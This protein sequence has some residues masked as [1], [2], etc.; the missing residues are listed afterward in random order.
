MNYLAHLYLSGNEPTLMIGNFIADHVK[1]KQFDLY[2]KEIQKGILLHRSIDAFTDQHAV[3]QQSKIIL[4]PHF[5]KYAPVIV[6]VFY[7]HFLARDWM[8]YHPQTLE[9]YS[10]EVYQLMNKNNVMLPER[11]RIMLSYMS[12]YN[13][14][15]SYASIDG[16]ERA[17]SGLASR[18]KFESR[19][20]EAPQFLLQ[21]YDLFKEH[22]KNFFN[23]LEN[24]VAEEKQRL[25][26]SLK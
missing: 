4:R 14:L 7:D 12:Q 3:V 1:G 26:N 15:L 23:E 17:L 18:T 21:H 16:M 9:E 19:M 2:S 6:D 20:E 5:H 24:H 13:W 22:F 25:K 11:A 10:N 8:E